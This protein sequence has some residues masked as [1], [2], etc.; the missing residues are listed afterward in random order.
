MLGNYAEQIKDF[1]KYAQ[2]LGIVL[3]QVKQLEGSKCPNCGAAL[4]ERMGRGKP[5]VGCSAFP[6]CRYIEPRDK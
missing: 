6:K 4:V 1:A 5:F 2:E 3:K